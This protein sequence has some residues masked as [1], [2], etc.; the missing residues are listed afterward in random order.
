MFHPVRSERLHKQVFD[1]IQEMILRGAIKPGERLP[2]ERE[3]GEALQVSRNS[4]REALRSLEVLGLLESRQGGGN[5]VTLDSGSALIEPLSL[6]FQLHGGKLMDI[7]DARRA[8]ES[9]AAAQAA[10]RITPLGAAALL[11]LADRYGS[12]KDE[13][14]CV[15]IDKELHM[16]IAELSG[17]ILLLGFLTAISSIFER[18]IKDGRRAIV[19]RIGS[20]ELLVKTHE[21]LCEAVASGKPAAAR[22]AVDAHFKMIVDNLP[23]V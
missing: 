4:V 22:K 12:E 20:H 14:A 23:E 21:K 18:S 1:Q 6:L 19:R 5:Y 11:A 9:E 13:R 3:L 10:S 8:L 7:L 15:L 17:N 2:S 16:K